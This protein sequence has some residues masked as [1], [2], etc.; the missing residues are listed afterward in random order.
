MAKKRVK[1]AHK[2]S[3]RKKK[4]VASR[5]NIH[6]IGIA[7]IFSCGIMLGAF[8]LNR[9]YFMYEEAANLAFLERLA[10]EQAR[11]A[12]KKQ[13]RL[14]AQALAN[15]EKARKRLTQ[16]R[17][18]AQ[19]QKALKKAAA[20]LEQALSLPRTQANSALSAPALPTPAQAALD[21][22]VRHIAHKSHSSLQ[23]RTASHVTPHFNKGKLSQYTP[24]SGS[25]IMAIVID[26]V[27]YQRLPGERT[28]AL[29]GKITL[30][31]LP[32]TPFAQ[33]LA[34]QAPSFNKEV[35]LHA[36][37]EPKKLSYWGDGLKTAMPEQELR[38]EFVAMINNIPNLVGVNNHM[39]SSLTENPEAMAWLMQE[40]PS[41]G[42]YFIDSRT[43]A[44]SKAY[45]AA[46]KM[47][48][49]SYVRD[50]FLDHSRDTKDINKQFDQLIR[51]AQ[52]RGM[53]LGIGHPY[54]ETLAVLE[55]RL[56]QLQAI[57]V[58]LV[59][60]SELLNAR[61]NRK[62]LASATIAQT[63]QHVQ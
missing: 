55:K 42:L 62:E 40:L 37:M 31:V 5:P 41:R 57:G 30:A 28:L 45:N 23:H 56:P 27:G 8:A 1:K 59:T 32:F 39:G 10:A 50:V 58:E 19:K 43:T 26:D 22:L 16:Q 13:Q 11:A 47:G 9:V 6:I 49:P 53:A 51:T 46:K 17:A 61:A 18:E 24:K 15:Q 20:A 35:M 7:A 63:K 60:V 21:P 33:K 52:K 38:R 2:K 36:P 34:A 12:H 3:V 54:P 44:G 25:N 48:I 14:K 4:G 29:P